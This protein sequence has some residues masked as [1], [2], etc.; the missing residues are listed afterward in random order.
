MKAVWNWITMKIV[1]FALMS[2]CCML[3]MENK[4]SAC[5]CKP[6]S[7]KQTIAR[8]HKEAA[9]VFIGEAR[10]VSKEFQTYRVVFVVQKA[11]KFEGKDEITIYTEGGCMVS[12]EAGKTYMVYADKDQSAK[13]YTNMCMRT[14]LVKYF[15]E[16]VK[17]LGRPAFVRERVTGPSLLPSFSASPDG[18]SATVGYCDLMR[19][20]EQ[21]K[22]KLV[23]VS[24][25]YRYGFEWSELY[26]LECEN[27]A[28]TWVD[29]DESFQ[30]STKS[31][32]RKKI[33]Y[34]GPQGR[35]VMV[36]FVGKFE[37]GTYGHMGAYAYRLLIN[38]LEKAEVI[39]N[40]S[41]SPNALPQEVL[42]KI[43]CSQS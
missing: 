37:Y 30:S 35:T 3:M 18:V 4:S 26:C 12:F 43:H 17:R 24:A 36:T 23:R 34:H 39:F 25:V 10:E 8:L 7:P 27:A 28:R 16:D 14:G 21:Y 9:A 6:E 38:R 22:G 2:V 40:D 20:A 15:D 11:W 1:M 29:F 41:P 19:S 31:S 5:L 32:L 42:S 33:G 13:L